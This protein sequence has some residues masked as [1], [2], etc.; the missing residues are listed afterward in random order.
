MIQSIVID[1]REP[2]NIQRMDYCCSRK[3]VAMLGFGDAWVVCDDGATL[4]IERKTPE[5]FVGSMTS[6][7][8]IDQARGL[9]EYRVKNGWWCYVVITGEL[10]ISPGGYTYAGE[11]PTMITW[12]AVQ[13]EILNIQELGVYVTFALNDNDYANTLVR[14]SNR[15]RTELHKIPRPTRKG[16]RVSN[17]TAFLAGIPGVGVETADK[18]IDFCGSPARAIEMI[19]NGEY[20]PGIGPE[21]RKKAVKVLGLKKSETMGILTLKGMDKNE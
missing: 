19:I 16:R 11:R 8:L 17:A 15:N 7:R 18:L 21:T 20:I 9:A 2:E 14:L 3:T 6:S 5:D 13:G 1:S 10:T 4:A 12:Q